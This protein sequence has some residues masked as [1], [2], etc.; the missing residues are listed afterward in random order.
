[1]QK[2]TVGLVLII[3]I[4]LGI[5]GYIFASQDS[6]IIPNITLSNNSTD[7]SNYSG[8]SD[9]TSSKSKSS[10]SSSYTKKSVTK[11]NK[12]ENDSEPV[13]PTDPISNDTKQK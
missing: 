12:T 4:L 3:V 9:L 6:Q 5:I 2:L 10:S 13:E 11:N 7:S 1:M 8:S